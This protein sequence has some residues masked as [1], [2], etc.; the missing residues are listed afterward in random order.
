MRRV[1]IC[2]LATLAL[3][4]VPARVTAEDPIDARIQALIDAR[5]QALE[6]RV[7]REESSLQ[8]KASAG[9]VVFLYGVFCALWRQNTGR[10]AWLWFILGVLFSFITVLFLLAKNSEDRKR[11]RA[12]AEQPG[13]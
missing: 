12:W 9:F 10:N 13:G 8:D 6:N 11:H 1:F 3:V 5:I 4:S 2:L 7:A